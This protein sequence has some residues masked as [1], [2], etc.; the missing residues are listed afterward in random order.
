[1]K[2]KKYLKLWWANV[3]VIIFIHTQMN[4][5]CCIFAEIYEHYRQLFICTEAFDSV[6]DKNGSSWE[7]AVSTEIIKTL[8]NLVQDGI[9][10]V[11]EAAAC[12]NVSVEKFKEYMK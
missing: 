5:I 4:C 8:V 3:A 10:N 2:Y 6:I 11:S 12:A 7:V 9:L 1:M